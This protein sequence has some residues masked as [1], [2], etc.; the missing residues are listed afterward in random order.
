MFLPESDDGT[1]GP[2]SL[3]TYGFPFWSTSHTEAYV[4]AVPD[5]VKI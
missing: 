5:V 3:P 1:F 4:R 2:I